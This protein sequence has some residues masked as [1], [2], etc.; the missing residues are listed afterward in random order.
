MLTYLVYVKGPRGP[1]PQ[2]WHRE[3]ETDHFVTPSDL[4]VVAGPTLVPRR[5]RPLGIDHLVKMLEAA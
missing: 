5:L 1:E 4:T 3:T 2:L